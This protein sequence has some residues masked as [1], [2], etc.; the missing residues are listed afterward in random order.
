M[1]KK[2]KNQ[3]PDQSAAYF[4]IMHM[5]KSQLSL[6]KAALDSKLVSVL[7]VTQSGNVVS[8]DMAAGDIIK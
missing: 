6:V 8:G 4:N 5:L 7:A 3:F 2:A 1:L